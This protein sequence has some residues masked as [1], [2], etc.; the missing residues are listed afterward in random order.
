[1]YDEC[2]IFLYNKKLSELRYLYKRAIFYRN[3][4]L[5]INKICIFKYRTI[6]RFLTT[7]VSIN[8]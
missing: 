1:M 2:D 8:K 7:N 3:F 6:I 4:I 5:N